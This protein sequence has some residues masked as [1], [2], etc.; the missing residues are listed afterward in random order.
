MMVF[1]VLQISGDLPRGY[2][3]GAAQERRE[4]ASR[5]SVQ[6]SSYLNEL[7]H[8]DP[9]LPSLELGNKGLRAAKTVR[10]RLLR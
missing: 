6:G 3:R 9:P 2:L 4:Q 8:V 1:E 10:K 5:V 7:C